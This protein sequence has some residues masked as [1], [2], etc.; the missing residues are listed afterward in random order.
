MHHAAEPSSHPYSKLLICLRP[1]LGEMF[2]RFHF[3]YLLEGP[4]FATKSR[5]RINSN[6]IGLD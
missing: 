5:W 3:H 2:G 4:G 6:T 1:E